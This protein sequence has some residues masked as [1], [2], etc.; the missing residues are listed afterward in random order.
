ML[1]LKVGDII[2]FKE[3]DNDCRLYITHRDSTS[4]HIQHLLGFVLGKVVDVAS[5]TMV[6]YIEDE[7]TYDHA[8]F[9]DDH[10]HCIIREDTTFLPYNPD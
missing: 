8:L 4:K 2:W 3:S 9:L 1:D 5:K 6:V 7:T 10:C